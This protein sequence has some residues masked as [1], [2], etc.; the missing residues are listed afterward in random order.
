MLSLL[1]NK[2]LEEKA[3]YILWG[4]EVLGDFEDE[5]ALSEFLFFSGLKK[6]ELKNKIKILILFYF[7]VVI[8]G[9]ILSS[10]KIIFLIPIGIIL[11]FLTLINLTQK[12]SEEFEKDYVP[13]LIALAS[14]IRTGLD[15]IVAFSKCGELFSEESLLRKKII[16]FENKLSKGKTEDEALVTFAD[17]IAH[18]DLKLFRSTMILA[19]REGASLATCLRRLAQVT[20]RR[21]SFRRKIK[22]ALALQ[23]LS[24]FGI[25]GCALIIAFIQLASNYEILKEAMA[26]PIGSI[27]IKT[28][29]SL[30]LLGL[31][32]MLYMSRRRI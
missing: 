4:D 6:R 23:K 29:I 15:P 7:F 12:R 10:Y 21:Q 1:R 26:N 31:G 19:R 28:S 13:F 27:A 16:E 22:S 20:R 11:Q 9:V 18:P 8:L 32:W 3:H 14:G 25:C 2:E 5:N 17:D 24:T 30:I